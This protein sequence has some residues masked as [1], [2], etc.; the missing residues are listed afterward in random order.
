MRTPRGPVNPFATDKNYFLACS[1]FSQGETNRAVRDKLGLGDAKVKKFRAQ[2][3]SIK[4]RGDWRK[5]F[6]RW[7]QKCRMVEKYDARNA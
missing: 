5:R 6:L 1:M 4:K 2:H 3:E 7:R